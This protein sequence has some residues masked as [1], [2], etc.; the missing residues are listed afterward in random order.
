MKV[1]FEKLIE[2]TDTSTGGWKLKYF[3]IL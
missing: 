2:V 3:A 1:P